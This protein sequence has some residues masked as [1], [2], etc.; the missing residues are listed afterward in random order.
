M[1]SLPK[2]TIDICIECPYAP[3]IAKNDRDTC[4]PGKVQKWHKVTN[5]QLDVLL[6][7]R[8]AKEKAL[9]AMRVVVKKF[10]K[11]SA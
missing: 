4:P 6:A 9:L 3:C 7:I 1:T 10:V 5:A 2:T 8:E 11:K